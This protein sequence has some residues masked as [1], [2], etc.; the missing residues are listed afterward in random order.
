M[1]TPEV[2]WKKL[3]ISTLRA[4]TEEVLS[5]SPA[6]KVLRDAYAEVVREMDSRGIETPFVCGNCNAP[7]DETSAKC[8]ACG[9]VIDDEPGDTEPEIVLEEVLERAKK[10]KIDVD[11][12]TPEE[13]VGLIEAVERKKREAKRSDLAGIE[14]KHLNEKLTEMMGDGWRKKRTT[15]YLA[16]FDPAGVRRI[17]VYHRG[18]SVHFSVDDGDLAG[19]A[20]IE[21][22]DAAERKRRHY[23]RTNY[24]YKG[25]VTKEAL[26]ACCVVVDKYGG[27]DR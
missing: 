18:L 22:Y 3:E 12:K 13:I 25:D 14:S 19:F 21:Y 4:A 16:Y 7:I 23:G 8:W 6:S 9:S 11:G 26:A 1:N 17:G 10:L 24:V 15:Q 20:G 2:N 5:F 27:R